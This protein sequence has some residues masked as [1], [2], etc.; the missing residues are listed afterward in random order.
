[1]TN[2]MAAT[3]NEHSIMSSDALDHRARSISTNAVREMRVAHGRDKGQWT[4]AD[5]RLQNAIYL[6]LKRMDHIEAMETG[7]EAYPLVSSKQSIPSAAISAVEKAL[8]QIGEM[9]DEEVSNVSPIK[10]KMPTQ[11]PKTEK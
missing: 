10:A 3:I 9:E 8:T 7:A 11:S 2:I 4:D 1:M 6:V 5:S